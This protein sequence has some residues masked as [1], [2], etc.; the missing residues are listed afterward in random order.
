M[1]G[2]EGKRGR[3]RRLPK[4]GEMG[5]LVI[6]PSGQSMRLCLHRDEGLG[7]K[8]ASKEQMVVMIV[9]ASPTHGSP[10]FLLLSQQAIAVRS[11]KLPKSSNG[12]RYTKGNYPRTRIRKWYITRISSPLES[13]STYIYF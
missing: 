10:L 7:R 2:G 3:G 12:E 8:G 9:S 4:V 11:C 1:R 6:Q 5:V 13:D